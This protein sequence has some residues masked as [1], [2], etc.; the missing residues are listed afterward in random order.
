M[1]SSK[2]FYWIGTTIITM[3]KKRQQSMQSYD[4][5][6]KILL[7]PSSM[8]FD[9]WPYG[10][11]TLVNNPATCLHKATE[12]NYD[13]IVIF[14]Q[15]RSLK[16][17]HA[18]V[19]LCSMLKRNRYTLHIP[20]LCLLPYRHREILEQLHDVGVEYVRL[21]D[22]RD[23]NLKNHIESLLAKPSEECKIGRILSGICPHINY[24]SIGQKNQEILYC[25]AYRNR[26][27]LGSYRLRHLCETFNHRNCQYFNYPIFQ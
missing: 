24:F 13:F 21:Y 25:G 14:H 19:E 8:C 26:L 20:L 10:N 15:F 4:K 23:P 1:L 6:Y 12:N 17:R 5:N 9:D 3:L 22:P 18:L 27:V 11:L 7:F 2:Y 16:E